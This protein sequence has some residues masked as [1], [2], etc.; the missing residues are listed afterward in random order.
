MFLKQSEKYNDIFLPRQNAHRFEEGA[1]LLP[2]MAQK[3]L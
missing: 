1:K 2:I 3:N